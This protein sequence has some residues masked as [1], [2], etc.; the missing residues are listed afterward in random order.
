[1]LAITNTLLRLWEDNLRQEN[2]KKLSNDKKVK[3]QNKIA[4]GGCEF[5]IVVAYASC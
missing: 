2:M 4:R 1:M 3:H 5:S